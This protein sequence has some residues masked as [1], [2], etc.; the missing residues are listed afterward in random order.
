[1]VAGTGFPI[2]D[3]TF[4]KKLSLICALSSARLPQPVTNVYIQSKTENR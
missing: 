4:L 1:M 3:S 2:K